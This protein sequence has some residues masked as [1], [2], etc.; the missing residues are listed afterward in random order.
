MTPVNNAADNL[1]LNIQDLVLEFGHPPEVVRALDGVTL[2]V[3]GGTIL[4]IVGE[5]GSGKSTIGFAAG[6]LM[7][8]GVRPKSGELTLLGRSVWDIEVEDMQEIRQQELRYV[9]QDPIATLDPTKRIGWQ[10]KNAV[11]PPLSDED[12]VNSLQSVGLTDASRVAAAWPHELS[13]GMAQ[14][15]VIAMATV[16]DPKVIIAD[17]A[18]SALDA[19]VITR[20]LELLRDQSRKR[21]IT[22]LLLSH[23]LNAM[24][25][26]CDRIAV[27]YAGRVVEHGPTQE[28]FNAPAHPYTQALLAASAG[29][30]KPGEMLHTIPGIPPALQ[31]ASKKCAFEPR[32]RFALRNSGE[33]SCDRTRP[34]QDNITEDWHILCHRWRDLQQESN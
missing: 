17:E 10:V 23:N 25:R 29:H 3:P 15:V 21:N 18:T 14:R 6:R 28:V 31:G 12:V 7:P 1:A 22:L 27:V 16:G 26:F 30:E 13:G 8:D 32:C 33:K 2:A 11:N 9:F 19:S 5:S 24:K 20:V 34:E 4:G